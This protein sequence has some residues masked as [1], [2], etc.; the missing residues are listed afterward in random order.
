MFLQPSTLQNLTDK[1]SCK[2]LCADF[3]EK[4]MFEY[5]VYVAIISNLL[6]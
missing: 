4:V 2:S 5:M 3:A 1:S 6:Q